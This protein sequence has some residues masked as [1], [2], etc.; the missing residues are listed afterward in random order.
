MH[1]GIDG[2]PSLRLQR[3][4]LLGMLFLGSIPK[5]TFNS[6]G[7]WRPPTKISNNE[8]AMLPRIVSDGRGFVHAVW[9][10]DSNPRPGAPGDTIYYSRWDGGGWSTPVDVLVS[11]GFAIA[12]RPALAVDSTDTVYVAWQSGGDILFSASHAENALSAH[13]WSQP[14]AILE[15]APLL[16]FVDL[17][18]SDQGV[19][20]I[21]YIR[22]SNGELVVSHAR[23]ENGGVV[24]SGPTTVSIGNPEAA[25]LNPRITL[26]CNDAVH[27]V[28]SE[29][30]YPAAWPPVGVYYSRS[31]D[32]GRTWT[33]PYQLAGYGY[34]NANVVVSPDGAVHALWSGTHGYVGR[35]HRWSAD[36]GDSWTEIERLPGIDDSF[37]QGFPEM[38]FD[39]QG[40]MHVV[41]GVETQSYLTWHD[42]SWT[43]P[44]VLAEVESDEQLLREGG[45]PRIALSRGDQL[46]VLFHDAW[47]IFFTTKSIGTE[48]EVAPSIPNEQR[49]SCAPTPLG[50]SASDALADRWSSSASYPEDPSAQVGTSSGGVHA[51]MSRPPQDRR[52]A[53]QSASAILLGVALSSLFSV[54]LVLR[55]ITARGKP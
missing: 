10:G 43:D 4:A 50:N 47:N 31:V 14:E 6:S 7:D 9:S 33:D 46:V 37:G 16:Y 1:R 32:G 18:A 25:P 44:E 49:R 28:W 24:W 12:T 27:I 30:Q 35:Y 22:E 3:M 36:G 8:Q 40:T 41:A 19:L 38:V 20:H 13:G 2:S 48:G 5:T 54:G 21:A 11:P 55:R 45:M 42:G 15:G 17:Q 39:E 23:S 34:G 53:T 52:P 29:V 51:E 26:R